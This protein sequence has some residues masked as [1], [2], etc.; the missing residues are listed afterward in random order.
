MLSIDYSVIKPLIYKHQDDDVQKLALQRSKFAQL[1]DAEFRFLLQQIEGRKRTQT[2]LPS[3]LKIADW[4]YPVRLSCEQ[5]SSETTALYKA[6]LIDHL[7]INTLIDLTGGYGIDIYFMSEKLD[8]AYYVERNED[9]CQIAA[10]NFSITRPHIE[11][12]NTTAETFLNTLEADEN[13]PPYCSTLIF[14]DPARRS[15][16][17][18]KVFRLEDCEPNL[19]TLLPQLKTIAAHHCFKLSP[20]VDIQ[21]LYM[22]LGQ[23]WDIHILAVDNEV[24]E[25]LMINGTGQIFATN[26][27]ANREDKL[28]IHREQEKNT[29]CLYATSIKQYIYE[30]NVAI[31]KAG[32]YKIIGNK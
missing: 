6:Q 9:L 4:W 12:H 21:S 32:A 29:T 8:K 10:H 23:N 11:L 13:K 25:I 7:S 15:E 20:M 26:I 22:S 5:C 24:K 19:I 14:I 30:P 3:L 1:T 31:I 18:S 2:K 28:A 17:G 27:H 16:S